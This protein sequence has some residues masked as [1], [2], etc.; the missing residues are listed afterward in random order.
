MVN[1]A[2]PVDGRAANLT[3]RISRDR[4]GNARLRFHRLTECDRNYHGPR[5]EYVMY[6][7]KPQQ[8]NT[9][10]ETTYMDPI[11]G[12]WITETTTTTTDNYDNNNYRD[13][14]RRDDYND[15][16]NDNRG[17]RDR[18]P[19][20]PAGPT[21]MDARTFSEVKQSI[22]GASFEDTKLSTAK[23]IFGTNYAS[24]E[25]IMEICNLFSFENTKV[26]FAKFAYSRCVDPQNYFKVGSV[27]SFDSNKKTLN[28][29]I[30]GGGR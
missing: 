21:A 4:S 30:S 17:H 7:G 1:I 19:V 28:D 29:F 5:D 15:Y 27:F 24:T 22:N 10:T 18:T 6:Y 14:N 26:T 20:P 16:R 13:N 2:D 9:V 3:L 12:Q 8:I 11:T 23:T 25:Q